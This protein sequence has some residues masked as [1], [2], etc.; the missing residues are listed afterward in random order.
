MRN[1]KQIAKLFV[2]GV[3][4][5]HYSQ[6]LRSFLKDFPVSGVALFNSPFDSPDNV[7]SQRDASLEAVYEFNQKI[8]NDVR[9]ISADQEGGRVRRLRGAFINLPSAQ[10][11]VQRCDGPLNQKKAYELYHLAAQQMFLAGI[12]LNF[13][14][15]CDLQTKESHN[16][17]GDRSYGSDPSV[18]IS[19]AKTFCDAFQRAGVL[20]TLKHFPGHGPSKMDSHEQAALIEKPLADYW[21]EDVGIFYQ[22]MPYAHLLMTGHLSFPEN[23]DLILSME[24][25]LIE[26]FLKKSSHRLPLIT[27]DLLSMKAVSQ[28]K[29]WI[30]AF[31]A[32]YSFILLCG[33]LQK[34]FQAIEETIRHAEKS[35]SSFQ[36]QEDL[37]KRIQQSENFL[38]TE[39]SL[40]PFEKWKSEILR[41]ENEGN[42]IL[43][44][45]GFGSHA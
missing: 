34:S 39:R 35:L 23:P 21:H 10:A 44:Q 41:C 2:V 33:D 6:E 22:L 26:T 29:P 31:D 18:V 19:W 25:R 30:R 43:H 17:V 40:L 32:P 16:V 37:E 1:W 36:Q 45:L 14:P 9:F 38:K 20:T 4:D 27:D 12:Q 7:W 11:L 15:V 13:A 5:F 42:E 8:L 3:K 28:M 24:T